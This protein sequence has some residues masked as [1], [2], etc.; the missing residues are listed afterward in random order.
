MDRIGGLGAGAVAEQGG[1]DGAD[2]EGGYDQHGMPGDRGMQPDLRLVETEAVLAELETFF[3]GPSQ[4]G[5]ADQ[6]GL[7]AQLSL[8]TKQ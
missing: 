2:R 7:G 6:P 1:G 3:Y 8:R 5:G 4:S